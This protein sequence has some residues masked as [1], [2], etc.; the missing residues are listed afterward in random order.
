MCSAARGANV[1][2]LTI[3]CTPNYAVDSGFADVVRQRAHHRRRG[4]DRG[5]VRVLDLDR[6]SVPNHQFRSAYGGVDPARPD[7]NHFS[8]DGALA[9][10]R[11][12]SPILLGDVAPPTRVQRL[13]PPR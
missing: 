6:Q 8:D 5:F 10:A 9:A 13:D 7:G 12:M 1:V 11:W 2:W 4:T 3:P